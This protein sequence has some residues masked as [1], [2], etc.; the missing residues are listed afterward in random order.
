MIK[1][2]TSQKGIQIQL[3]I[4]AKV[5]QQLGPQLRQYL[6]WY[7]LVVLLGAWYLWTSWNTQIVTFYSVKY[8]RNWDTYWIRE[9]TGFLKS[10]SSY[11]QS[12]KSYFLKIFSKYLYSISK[13]IYWL[14]K[15]SHIRPFCVIHGVSLY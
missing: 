10:K 11:S 4:S 1:K 12:N 3:H 14:Y 15:L 7:F 2:N 5:C 9:Y 6:Y 8:L 13:K